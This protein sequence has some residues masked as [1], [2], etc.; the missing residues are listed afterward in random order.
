[1]LMEI[2]GIIVSIII[3]IFS[4][5]GGRWSGLAYILDWPTLICML[6]LTLPVLSKEGLAKDF[7]R[8]F[9]LLRKE[10]RC[11]FSELRH[12][13]DVVE[14]MQ[15]QIFCAGVIVSFQGFFALLHSLDDLATIGPNASVALL[16]IF[17]TAI[18]ELLMLPL[19]IEAK[20]RI[21]DYI[22]QEQDTE[23]AGK[24]QVTEEA[25]KE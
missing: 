21:V 1:M 23:D 9:K 12:A 13:L 10:Y 6:I 25:E 3:M 20:R 17:Y 15:K 22:E 14:M 5:P 11:S 24:E 8:A 19:Q 7:L 16:A 18:F 4:I 2:V